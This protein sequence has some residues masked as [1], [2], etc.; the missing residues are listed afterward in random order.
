MRKRLG[1]AP[2]IAGI[3]LTTDTAKS[4]SRAAMDIL[5]NNKASLSERERRMNICR[6]CPE[7]NH[8]RCGLC[9]CFIKTKTI[10]ASSECPVGKWSI[11][12]S[13][14]DDAGR[15]EKDEERADD[16]SQRV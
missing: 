11:G 12:K 10:L 4:L 2:K 7:R 14:V 15:A 6:Q 5:A 13:S 9:G 16:P 8:D 1:R 3:P